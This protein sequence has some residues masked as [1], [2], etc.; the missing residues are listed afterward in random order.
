MI[1]TVTSTPMDGVVVRWYP[2]EHAEDRGREIASA[3]RNQ[4]FVNRDAPTWVHEAA[5][6]AH[7]AL[8]S[9]RNA[10]VSHLA[11]HQRRHFLGKL[12]PINSKENES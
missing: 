1:V 2:N 5:G 9:D 4:V 6:D 10:D 3:S 7:E 8:R 12:E 11:T